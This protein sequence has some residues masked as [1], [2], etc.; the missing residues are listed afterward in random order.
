MQPAVKK[1]VRLIAC[2]VV[3]LSLLVCGRG[4]DVVDDDGIDGGF[5]RL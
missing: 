4:V 1:I 3:S 5:G 2:V